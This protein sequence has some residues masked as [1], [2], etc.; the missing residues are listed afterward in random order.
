VFV[1]NFRIQGPSNPAVSYPYTIITFDAR[2]DAVA[3]TIENAQVREWPVIPMSQDQRVVLLH[4]RAGSLLTERVTL[5]GKARVTGG[6]LSVEIE[7]G[8]YVL[9]YDT[10]KVSR[11]APAWG[12]SKYG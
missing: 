5:V 3:R 6:N 7:D 11:V 10:F 2:V 8:H 12:D 4:P 1:V 9:A